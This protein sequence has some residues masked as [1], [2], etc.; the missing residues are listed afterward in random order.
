MTITRKIQI[1][2]LAA[3]TTCAVMF[4]V[5]LSSLSSLNAEA[6]RA[7]GS[8]GNVQAVQAAFASART[9]NIVVLILGVGLILIVGYFLWRALVV[10]LQTM[11]GTIA[12]TADQLDFTGAISVGSNDEIGQTLQAYNRLMERLRQSFSEIQQATGHMLEVTEEVD[13]TSRKIARNSQIQSDAS[14]NMAAAVEEMTVSISVVAQQ[15]KDANQYT[16]DSSD[17][18]E[19]SAGAILTT[20]N[21]IRTI[22]DSVREASARIKTLRTDCDGISSMAGTIREIADQTNL[23]ALNAAIEAARAGEQGRGF[24]VVADEVRKLAERTAKSTHEITALVQRMQ[25]SA[26]SAVDSMNTTEVA[27]GHG[28]ENA[29]QAGDSIERIKEGSSSAA[30]V[31]EEI[32]G[33][34]REQQTASTQIAQ[35]IEQIAQMSEQNS[36]AAAASATAVGKIGHVGREIVASLSRYRIDSGPKALEIRVADIHGDEHPA[37]R[38]L[39]HMAELL[40]ERSGGQIRLRVM[41]KGSFGSEKD[42]LEGLKNGALDMTRTMLSSLNKDCPLTVVP[43]M[44]F[45]FRS[46]DHMQ[47]SMDGE[48]GQKIL[49]SCA[50]GNFIGLAFYD[51]GARSVYANKAIRSLADMRGLKLRVPQSDLWIAI[52][53]AMGAQATPMALDEIIAG[54]RMGLVE[55]AENNLPS[56]EGFKHFEIFQQYSFT[57]HSMAPD[58][59]VFSKRRWDGL[60]AEQQQLISSSARDSVAVMRRYWKEREETARKTVSN[61]GSKFVQDVNKQSFQNAM[62]PVYDQFITSA[63]QKNLLRAIQ[64]FR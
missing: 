23:L 24:A 37:V 31:V 21:G 3:L 59:V 64:D 8:S 34:I 4:G 18:A 20:V 27:V 58:I 17:I 26:R 36:A 29:Q 25:E 13:V 42:A 22:A 44:P 53:K 43:G 48:P 30:G 10:P 41:S 61:G 1:L 12:R 57:E 38:A 2:I 40:A 33:A 54:Q 6:A 55:A 50:A 35:N 47:R 45:L 28:V 5:A 32:A 56:Y 11:Q 19:H 16:Q 63:D 51:S 49:A 39:R 14:A 52:A 9:L 7:I 46:I 60:S 15:A 62:K